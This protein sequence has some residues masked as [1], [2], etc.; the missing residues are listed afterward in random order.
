MSFISLVTTASATALI[1]YKIHTAS[2][3]VWRSKSRYNRILTT[4]IQ[5]SAVYSLVLLLLIL[6]TFIPPF[7]TIE[8]PWSEVQF[9]LEVILSVVSVCYKYTPSG[10]QYTW[11]FQQGMAP[12]GMVARL[13]CSSPGNTVSPGTITHIYGMSLNSQHGSWD[14]RSSADDDPDGA[15]TSFA[16]IENNHR[17]Q[18]PVMD[19][20]KKFSVRNLIG[21][22]PVWCTSTRLQSCAVV[23]PFLPLPL[24][25]VHSPFY[26]KLV[27]WVDCLVS[28]FPVG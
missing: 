28:G 8:S 20:T 22:S 25:I 3:N 23:S 26:S 15:G 19:L 21:K 4:I 9:Y 5:S 7:N 10:I 12:T 24:P 18:P 6:T 27:A 1:G 14:G 2:E 11:I 17:S 16:H 13:A